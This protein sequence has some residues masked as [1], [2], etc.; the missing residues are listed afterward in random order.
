MTSFLDLS[1]DGIALAG[2]GNDGRVRQAHRTFEWMAAAFAAAPPLTAG[3]DGAAHQ[4]DDTAE[5][6]EQDEHTGRKR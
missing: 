5:H 4:A 1:R 6:T 3:P 2:P